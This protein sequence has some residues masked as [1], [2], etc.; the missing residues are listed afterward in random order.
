M[1]FCVQWKLVNKKPRVHKNLVLVKRMKI[2]LYIWFT[3][4]VLVKQYFLLSDFVL[5]G[6]HS[7]FILVM[8]IE[9]K[10]SMKYSSIPY[11]CR[12]GTKTKWLKRNLGLCN[13][14]NMHL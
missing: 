9:Q 5:T 14:A 6:S 2:V 12:D 7:F 13:S 3:E 10:C 8:C 1:N 11:V 4:T